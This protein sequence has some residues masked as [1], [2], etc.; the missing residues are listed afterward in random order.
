MMLPSRV[1]LFNFHYIVALCTSDHN[2]GAIIIK[3]KALVSVMLFDLHSFVRGHRA[4]EEI[5]AFL[6]NLERK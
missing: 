6:V 4:N 3:I 1:H 2:S 5:L